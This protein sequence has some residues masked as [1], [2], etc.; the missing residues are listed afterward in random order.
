M[1]NETQKSLGYRQPDNPVQLISYVTRAKQKELHDY[2]LPVS[3]LPASKIRKSTSKKK[4]PEAVK[5]DKQS[6]QISQG[7]DGQTQYAESPIRIRDPY[8]RDRETKANNTLYGSPTKVPGLLPEHVGSMYQ[9]AGEFGGQLGK[10]PLTRSDLGGTAGKASQKRLPRIIFALAEET[11]DDSL[12]QRTGPARHTTFFPGGPKLNNPLLPVHLNRDLSTI[13]S[14]LEKKFE[15]PP[16]AT[17]AIYDEKDGMVCN[18]PV[19]TDDEKPTAYKPKWT[20]AANSRHHFK[21][22]KTVTGSTPASLTHKRNQSVP[23]P[24]MTPAFMITSPAGAGRDA[25]RG[26]GRE[27]PFVGNYNVPK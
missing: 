13:R 20:K 8:S 2:P 17:I 21:T 6:S 4:L 19:L 3:M 10:G 12:S 24:R 1:R 5:I 15:L 23:R 18:P 9:T 22:S 11:D 7:A 27:Q 14:P 26:D 16:Q 25:G